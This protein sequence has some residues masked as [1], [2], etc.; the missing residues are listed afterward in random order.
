[1]VTR[2]FICMFDEIQVHLSTLKI[3]KVFTA[4]CLI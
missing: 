1:M 3:S 4:K 2:C